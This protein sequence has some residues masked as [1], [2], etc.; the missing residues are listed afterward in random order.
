MGACLSSRMQAKRWPLH[1]LHVCCFCLIV[2]LTH[3]GMLATEVIAA[4]MIICS[5]LHVLVNILVS[6]GL[7][8]SGDRGV[9]EDRSIHK[10]WTDK[11]LV[12]FLLNLSV[13]SMSSCDAQSKAYVYRGMS[14][15]ASSNHPIVRCYLLLH[16][17]KAAGYLNARKFLHMYVLPCRDLQ[18]FNAVVGTEISNS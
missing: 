9:C 15:Q 14:F 4:C 10:G 11:Q 3:L 8:F 17:S 13:A 1:T 16:Y 5:F 7:H 2:I 6:Q 12:R 18:P